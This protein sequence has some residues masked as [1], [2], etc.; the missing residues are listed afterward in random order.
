MKNKLTIISLCFAT[1]AFAQ[2]GGVPSM[3]SGEMPKEGSTRMPATAN[4]PAAA[5][6]AAP[7]AMNANDQAFVNKATK[8]SMMEVEWGKLAAQNAQNPDV[9]KFGNQMITDHT[10]AYNE[11][12][13]LA[14]KKGVKVKGEKFKGKWTSD[15][16]YMDTMVK[17][18]QSAWA[19]FQAEAKNGT[20]PDLK[21]WAGD[22]SKVIEKHLK[23]AKQTQAKLK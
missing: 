19:D 2:E 3:G 16:D 23:M 6:T 14:N 9:K 22:T 18:H 11:L 15:K 10:K 17:D 5:N 1:V 13:T 4:R 7:A 20:D 12:M 21:K 8:G